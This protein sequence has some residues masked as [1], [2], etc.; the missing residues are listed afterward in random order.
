MLQNVHNPSAWLAIRGGQ[1]THG[2]GGPHCE[3]VP[4]HLGGTM[5]DVVL[6]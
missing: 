4:N 6:T 5:L 3:F 2:V 1:L